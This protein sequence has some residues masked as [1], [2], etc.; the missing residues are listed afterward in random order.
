VPKAQSDPQMRKYQTKYFYSL[1][2]AFLLL[3]LVGCGSGEKKINVTYVDEMDSEQVADLNK[4]DGSA[5]ARIEIL[6]DYPDSAKPLDYQDNPQFNDP[7]FDG[8]TRRAEDVPNQDIPVVETKVSFE[9]KVQIAL[10]SAGYY[11]SKID[12]KIGSA[13]RKAIKSFQTANDLKA[14]GLVGTQT[15][16][17]LKPFYA[18]AQDEG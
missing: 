11:G 1:F 2:V 5:Y 12:G 10:R 15:W 14:D 13:T 6:S 16:D 17:K 8:P 9:Q 18:S 4:Q 7:E 3:G